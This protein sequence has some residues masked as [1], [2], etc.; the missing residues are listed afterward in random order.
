MELQ[1][2]KPKTHN[3]INVLGH[4]KFRHTVFTR[5]EIVEEKRVILCVYMY[6]VVF[7]MGKILLHHYILTKLENREVIFVTKTS[8]V[9]QTVKRLPKTQEIRVQSLGQKDPLDKEMATH[10]SILA[11]KMPWT[12]EPGGPQTMGSQ[13]VGQG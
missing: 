12:E 13:R 3:T 9:A 10:S 7:F 6:M 4:C 11:W 5:K 8:L 1:P 2:R